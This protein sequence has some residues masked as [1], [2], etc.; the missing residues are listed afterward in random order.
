MI[1][2]GL[3][4]V[5]LKL[6]DPITIQMDP[7]GNIHFS[8]IQMTPKH[9]GLYPSKAIYVAMYFQIFLFLHE[10]VLFFPTMKE[11]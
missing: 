5:R 4:Y 11:Y 10:R 6:W 3:L 1:L 2:V 7:I 9:S 8:E